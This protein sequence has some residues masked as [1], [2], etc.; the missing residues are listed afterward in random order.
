M[1]IY[2]KIFIVA[3]INI[4]ICSAQDATNTSIQN[5]IAI[6]LGQSS[7]NKFTKSKPAQIVATFPGND[8][9]SDSYLINGYLEIEYLKERQNAFTYALGIAYEVQKN[10]LIDKEQDVKQIGITA[11]QILANNYSDTKGQFILSENIKYSQNF[12]KKTDAFQAHLGFKYEDFR[13]KNIFFVDGAIPLIGYNQKPDGLLS[14]RWDYNLGVGYI[15]GDEEVLMCKA[16]FSI[17][18]FPLY[19]LL[20]EWIEQPEMIFAS[21]VLDMR[22]PFVG[23]TDLDINPKRV[24]TFGIAY[25]I[26]DKSKLA[27]GYAFNKGADPFSGLDNQDFNTLSLQLNL[28]LK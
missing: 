22:T 21:Y 8:T 20:N 16:N 10:T 18:L 24:V 25:N 1:K 2:S 12:I 3:L 14:F 5:S 7:Q 17:S 13:P 11:T 27:L 26:N 15:G 4:S 28:A 6:N 19:G 23:D 9:I